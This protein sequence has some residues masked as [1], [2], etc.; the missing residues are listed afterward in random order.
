MKTINVISVRQINVSDRLERIP[1]ITQAGES[2]AFD[3][4]CTEEVK[5]QKINTVKGYL[6]FDRG[7]VNS[8][9]ANLGQ[10]IA[11]E[12]ESPELASTFKVAEDPRKEK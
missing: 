11:A 10:L 1:T 9:K 7:F 6:S 12:M 4:A 8:Q 2:S 5:E 3:D